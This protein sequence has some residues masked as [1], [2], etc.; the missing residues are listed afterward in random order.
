MKITGMGV[1]NAIDGLSPVKMHYLNIA[2][3]ALKAAMDNY[4]KSLREN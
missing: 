2:T 1:A 3:D 4:Y